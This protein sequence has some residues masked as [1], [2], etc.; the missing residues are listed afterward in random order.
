VTLLPSSQWLERQKGEETVK[1]TGLVSL[2]DP[3]LADFRV[4][5]FCGFFLAG[6]ILTFLFE[7][8]DQA[9]LVGK[10]P[11]E[12]K[13]GCFNSEKIPSGGAVDTTA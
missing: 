6:A 3:V 4:G 11:F 12:T 9:F 5:C 7:E 1:D 10:I 13:G 2:T 8:V